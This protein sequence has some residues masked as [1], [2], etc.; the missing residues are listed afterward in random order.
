[1]ADAPEHFSDTAQEKPEVNDVQ[2]IATEKKKK[3]KRRRYYISS[4]SESSSSDSNSE[5]VNKRRKGTKKK[6]SENDDQIQKQEIKKKKWSNDEITRLI[7]L[8]EAR[9]CLWDVFS[10]EHHNRETTAKAK[11]EIEVGYTFYV[12]FC[13]KKN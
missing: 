11:A 12:C 4:S 2:I 1:M 6:K 10:P 3:K 9:P 8:Y 5:P 13:E 7:D